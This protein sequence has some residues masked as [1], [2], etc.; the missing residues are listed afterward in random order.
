MVI[1][2]YINYIIS[3]I[4][5]L[6]LPLLIRFSLSYLAYSCQSVAGLWI[7][8]HWNHELKDL[9]CKTN[10]SLTEFELMKT[11]CNI[12]IIIFFINFYHALY[13]TQLS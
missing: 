10:A 2:I 6:T 3:Y 9:E 4:F 8:S 1:Y 13:I 11:H 12:V 5:Y 7:G